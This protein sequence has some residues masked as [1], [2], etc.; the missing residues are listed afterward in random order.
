MSH[1]HVREKTPRE[2]CS[3]PSSPSGGDREPSFAALHIPALL[4]FSSQNNADFVAK[5]I[6]YSTE[7]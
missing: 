7:G 5:E 4:Y 3:E 6:F 1:S 2:F